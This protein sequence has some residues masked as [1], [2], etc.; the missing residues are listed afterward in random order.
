MTIKT[1]ILSV[2]LCKLVLTIAFASST[3]FAGAGHHGAVHKEEEFERGP[4]HGRMLRQD[5]FALE[6][7]LFEQG[8]PPEFR[9]YAS[10]DGH[11]IRPHQVE[12]AIEL[13]RLGGVVDRINFRPEND[14][15]RGDMTIYEPHSFVVK[16]AAT[17]EGKRYSWS[18]ENFEGR[19]HISDE[20]AKANGV[21]TEFVGPQQL[22]QSTKV[23]GKLTVPPNAVRHIRAR[24][25]GVVKQ[26]NVAFGQQV[27][28]GQLLMRI[29]SNES[30]QS[31]D[32]RSPIDGVITMQEVGVGELAAEQTLLTITDTTV[33]VAEL[34]VF[35]LDQQ[36]IKLGAKVELT[37]VLGSGELVYHSEIKDSLHR[38]NHRQAKIFRALIDNQDQQLKVGQFVTAQVAT[39]GFEVPMAVKATGLQSFRDFTVVYAKVGEDYEVRMLSL[40]RRAG[41]W[42]EVLSGIDVGTEY[43]SENS[44]IIK[45][46][47][48]KSGASHDH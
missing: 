19:T 28:K 12:L 18:Y 26:L 5:H 44:Y 40:G 32:V 27:K 31:Y 3:V 13:I 8:I 4:H 29:E 45:A 1:Q 16:V 35:A 22:T 36:K 9:V 7:T 17:F 46:D 33:L 25:V 21:K 10:K 6:L 11:Q 48:D 23:Y 2:L 15:L 43:V 38:V 37:P 34:E 47:I 39:G 24:F 14:Y 30:L 20:M 42:V 41:E